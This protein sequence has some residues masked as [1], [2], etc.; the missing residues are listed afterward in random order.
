M[1]LDHRETSATWLDKRDDLA[2]R[3]GRTSQARVS[4]E[5]TSCNARAWPRL[6][7][8]YSLAGEV[9]LGGSFIDSFD[10]CTAWA[11]LSVQAGDISSPRI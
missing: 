11:T 7:S 10:Q 4:P 8:I 2:P 6:A 1:K 5:P 9:A 3:R